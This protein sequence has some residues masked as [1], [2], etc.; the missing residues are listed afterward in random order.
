MD[1][2]LVLEVWIGISYYLEKE[3]EKD[4]LSRGNIES[5]ARRIGKEKPKVLNEGELRSLLK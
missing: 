3:S 5:K 4:P 2:K 1:Y